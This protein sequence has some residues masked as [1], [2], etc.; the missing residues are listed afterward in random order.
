[1]PLSHR[2]LTPRHL[3]MSTNDAVLAVVEDRRG[4]G[5]THPSEVRDGL[6]DIGPEVQ[7]LD[8]LVCVG[9]VRVIVRARG[10]S[11]RSEYE[12]HERGKTSG[13]D[14]GTEGRRGGGNRGRGRKVGRVR[15]FVSVTYFCLHSLTCIR[16]VVDELF[17]RLLEARHW[18]HAV[19]QQN[20]VR[21]IPATSDVCSRQP[22]ADTYIQDPTKT[23]HKA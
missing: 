16:D 6:Y 22:H 10:M 4:G 23:M 13:S 2:T 18:R 5:H 3:L 8:D 1:M 7:L 17:G 11:E 15:R 20:D 9:W 21:R 19:F 12:R 14:G